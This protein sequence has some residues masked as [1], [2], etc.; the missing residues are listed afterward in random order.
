MYNGLSTTKSISL[1]G[2]QSQL[3]FLDIAF[4]QYYLS[5][6]VETRYQEQDKYLLRNAFSWDFF[7][8]WDAKPLLPNKILFRKGKEENE[9]FFELLGNLAKKKLGTDDKSILSFESDVVGKTISPT[10]EERYYRYCFENS[11]RGMEMI[12]PYIVKPRTREN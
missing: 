12:V 7:K 10:T 3:P 5:L 4:V 9:T 8:S 2:L 6:P 11:Y 1:F